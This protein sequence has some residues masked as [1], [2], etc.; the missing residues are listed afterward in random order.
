[1]LGLVLSRS[2][3][4]VAYRRGWLPGLPALRS[5]CSIR[6]NG[7]ETALQKLT[8]SAASLRYLPIPLSL[9]PFR[10]YLSL[11]S[12]PLVSLKCESLRSS[13]GDGVDKETLFDAVSIVETKIQTFAA[14]Q[15]Q[16]L[17]L[18]HHT[19]GGK[20]LGTQ[21]RGSPS[22]RPVLLREVLEIWSS[23]AVTACLTRC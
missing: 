15:L 14:G 19:H 22:P 13:R 21:P 20:A 5:L 12:T 8:I 10:V 6:L 9:L 18:G 7:V 17:V 1:M 23:R 3:I 4:D 16:M 11:F 2:Y